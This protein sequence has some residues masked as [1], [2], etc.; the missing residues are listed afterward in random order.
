MGQG[1][2]LFSFPFFSE[3]PDSC[4][5]EDHPYAGMPGLSAGPGA[6]PGRGS[7]AGSTEMDAGG[8]LRGGSK[9]EDLLAK[10]CVKCWDSNSIGDKGGRQGRI[11][12]NSNGF[13]RCR[14]RGVSTPD[15]IV[16]EF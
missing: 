8:E 5:A 3:D 14:T 7:G 9:Q 16:T 6:M 11:G 2:S 10:G 15:L 13:L 12:V 1:E 4:L